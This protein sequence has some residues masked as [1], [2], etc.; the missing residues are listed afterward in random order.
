MIESS[1]GFSH[2]RVTCPSGLTTV[3]KQH[4]YVLHVGSHPS[5]PPSPYG[6]A[7]GPQTPG[8]LRPLQTGLLLEPLQPLRERAQDPIPVWLIPREIRIPVGA[9]ASSIPSYLL[10]LLVALY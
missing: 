7:I 1:D 5:L 10:D 6:V 4:H 2:D 9:P 8:N 3:P